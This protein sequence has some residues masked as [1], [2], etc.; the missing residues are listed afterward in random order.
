MPRIESRIVEVCIFSI[1]EQGPEYLLLRRSPDEALFPGIW[2]FVSGSLEEGENAAAAA[3][4]E[5]GEE[6]SLVPDE[7]WVAPHVNS[8][9]DP[10]RDALNLTPVFA[11]RV[12]PGSV[13]KLSPEHSEYLWCDLESAARRLLWPGQREALRIVHEYIVGG[14]DAAGRSRLP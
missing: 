8:H 1:G 5:M 3:R 12:P 6:T 9:Y 7:F 11:A 10:S 13:P 2:Q 4:R 14:S